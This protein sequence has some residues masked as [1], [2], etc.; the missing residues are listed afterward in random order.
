M[1]PTRVSWFVAGAAAGAAGTVVGARKVK[2]VANQL[3]PVN[4]AKGAAGRVSG[5]PH[6]RCVSWAPTRSAAS[7]W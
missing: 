2:T 7:R 1:V 3:K 6:R 4:V 5:R